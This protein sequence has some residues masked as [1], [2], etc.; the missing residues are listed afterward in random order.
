MD[1]PSKCLPPNYSNLSRA[2]K[3]GKFRVIIESVEG[4]KYLPVLK[5][6]CVRPQY[7]GF[8]RYYEGKGS[9]RTRR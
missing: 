6:R 9:S 8:Y 7:L 2:G 4:R 3:V 5:R 1:N